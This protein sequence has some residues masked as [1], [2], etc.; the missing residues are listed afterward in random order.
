MRLANLFSYLAA[1]VFLTAVIVLPLQAFRHGVGISLGEITG[2]G[3]WWFLLLLIPLTPVV[4][5]GMLGRR[6]WAWWLGMIVLAIG[7]ILLFFHRIEGY[8]AWLE[9]Q[10]RGPGEASDE[11]VAIVLFPVYASAMRVVLWCWIAA[12]VVV[13][14]TCWHRVRM[15]RHVDQA[16]QERKPIDAGAETAAAK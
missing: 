16:T 13:S 15:L 5:I 1:A 4:C 12:F 7:V 2:Y 3:L 9:I 8:H 6:L 14:I 10:R 11:R